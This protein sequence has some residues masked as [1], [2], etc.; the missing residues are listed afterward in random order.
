MLHCS[1]QEH[2]RLLATRFPKE[3][4]MVALT[5]GDSRVSGI[6]TKTATSNAAAAAP[7]KSWFARFLAAMMESR[8]RQAEREVRLYAR[9]LPLH[10][11]Q[12]ELPFQDV[13]KDQARG[14]W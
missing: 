2:P 6:D 10:T 13:G 7:A 8:M 4:D 11:E 1:S 9:L 5:Y 12:G 14:G 3:N